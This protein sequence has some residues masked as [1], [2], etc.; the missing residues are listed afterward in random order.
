VDS[1]HQAD[2][3]WLLN[4]QTKLYQWSQT[5]PD[6]AYRDLWN[7][8]TD[9]HNLRCA[10]H[11]IA[12]NK[13]KRTPGVDGV[14]VGD[15]RRT[16]GV[17]SWLKELRAE[18]RNGSFRPSPCRRRL[19]PKPGKPGKFR[20]LGI[21]T[22]ADRVVQGAVK[23]ILE[24]IFEAQFWHVSY[25]F[26][27]NRNAQGALEH[28]RMTM[29]PRAKAEDGMRRAPPY[30]WVIEGDI[31]GCFDNIDHHAVMLRLRKRVADRRVT[32]LV[33]RFLKAG[34]LQEGNFL[35]TPAGTP[36]GGVISPL[37]A[38]IALSAIEER[39]ERWVNQR[40]KARAHRK[41]SGVRAA[42]YARSTDRR[43]G[44]SVFF[45][46]RYADDFVILVSGTRQ[47]ALEEKKQIALYLRETLGLE[48]SEEK[49]KVGS[50]QDGFTFLGQ[51]ARL[52][53]DP[54]YGFTPRIE[55]PKAKSTDVRHRVKQITKRRTHRSLAEVLQDLNPLLR[56]WG[57]YYRFCTG[58][59]DV[60]S[61]LD[62]YVADRL[63]RWMRKKYPKASVRWLLGHKGP[64]AGYR[65]AVW[66]AGQLEQFLTA[67]LTVRRYQRGWMGTPDYAVALG[68]PDA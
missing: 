40:T 60:F 18:L 16:R 34:A 55:I 24:P 43:R 21:P 58:A 41:S 38:N 7:W 49:T 61:R 22:V 50:L 53:W 14:T 52:R 1:D 46:V 12:S 68:E 59:K 42:L 23:Q 33:T 67:S 32:R 8:V 15:I 66:R 13:G 35:R 54:R 65:Q 26:R 47:D 4:V 11:T 9:P 37:L 19:I 44:L 36:Q 2:K 29:R 6:D 51:R 62:W 25:G 10:W 39:Y 57:C 3:A 63:W 17:A 27:P 30:Q 31:K 48:L 56:G 64:R 45:P 20:P 28:I 5:H